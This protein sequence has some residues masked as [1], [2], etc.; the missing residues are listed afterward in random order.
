MKSITLFLVML[1]MIAGSVSAVVYINTEKP[2]IIL[3]FDDNVSLTS[4]EIDGASVDFQPSGYATSFWHNASLSSEPLHILSVDAVDSEGR[5][6]RNGTFEYNIYI[7]VVAPKLVSYSP[8]TTTIVRDG[9]FTFS[10]EFD[11]PV[12]INSIEYNFG[13]TQSENKSVS[14]TQNTQTVI[15]GGVQLDASGTYNLVFSI[16]DLGGNILTKTVS[17][18]IITSL[19]ISL[20]SPPNGYATTTP[21]DLVVSTD[22]NADCSFL[23]DINGGDYTDFS[24]TGERTHSQTGFNVPDGSVFSLDITCYEEQYDLESTATFPLAVDSSA[25]IMTLTASD[26]TSLNLLSKVLVDINEPAKCAYATS[27]L[28]F[29]EMTLLDGGYD[30]HFEIINPVEDKKSYTYYV[31]CEN[32][33]ELRTAGNVG[34]K[35][36]TALKLTVSYIEPE[37]EYYANDSHIIEVSTTRPSVC[38]YSINNATSIT[39]MSGSFGD[40]ATTHKTTSIKFENGT[41]RIYVSC[42]SSNELGIVTVVA[43]KTIIIDETPPIIT[44]VNDTHPFEKN[45]STYDNSSVHIKVEAE[46]LE[47]G[48]YKYYYMVNS[49]DNNF[50]TG[51]IRSSKSKIIIDEDS[52]G[53]RFQLQDGMR[54]YVYVRVRNKAMIDSDIFKS[55]GFKIDLSLKPTTCTN[56]VFD[57]NDETAVD[58]G[59]ICGACEKDKSCVIDSDCKTGFCNNQVCTEPSCFDSVKNGDETDVDCGGNCNGCSNDEQ[60]ILDTDCQTGQCKSFKCFTPDPCEN[61]IIDSGE[62]DIDC[63][64][65]CLQKCLD[66]KVCSLDSDCLNANCENY[67][68]KKKEVVIEDPEPIGKPGDKDGDGLPDEW[69][70]SHGLDPN[71]PD[72][73]YDKNSDGITYIEQY[74]EKQNSE[75]A[76]SKWWLWLLL[77]LLIVVLILVGGYTYI[78]ETGQ[79]DKLPLG[80]RKYFKKKPNKEELAKQRQDILNKYQAT[81]KTPKMPPQQPIKKGVGRDINRK[82]KYKKR[83]DLFKKF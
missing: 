64:G 61:G 19:N 59:G 38:K 2:D 42:Q 68:C 44:S 25:P 27:D 79:E 48:I 72:D 63:G 29:G 13:R 28:P 24:T 78:V 26:I 51:W 46:D 36:D 21:V 80:I 56:G 37:N 57:K 14:F 11:E 17:F 52:D 31:I 16:T 33:A 8:T 71:N 49:S 12:D 4:T 1:L 58:C 9:S 75:P 73:A 40:T 55:D 7:D 76:G 30:T 23:L 15:T 3:Y 18:D 22:R 20:V 60:C 69:E 65:I 70:L 83:D 54:Y 6:F 82:L 43:D 50:T 5:S 66:G 32:M 77:V 45:G 35:V 41:N 53:D 10:L 39:Q 62:A 81:H 67:A 47:S 34:F 74:L